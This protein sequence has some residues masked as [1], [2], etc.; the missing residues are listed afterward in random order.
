[1]RSI[2]IFSSRIATISPNPRLVVQRTPLLHANPSLTDTAV[3][4]SPS[5]LGFLIND[6]L[7]SREHIV[8][9]CRGRRRAQRN[10]FP[11]Q[12]WPIV[13][14]VKYGPNVTMAEALTLGWVAKDLNAKP[15]AAVR[16]PQVYDAF[17]ITTSEWLIGYIV[18]EYIDALDCTKR[19]VKLVVLAVQTLI[20]VR[21]PSSAPGPVGGGP[22]VHAF[23]GDRTSP[24]TYETVEELQQHMDDVNE[25]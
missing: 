9:M 19:D 15:E 8:A 22:V 10:P 1:M 6:N 18:M 17:S 24:F 13:A 20:S 5:D 25:H 3:T 21:G 11:Q 12:A 7:P 4:M 2:S 16:I 23:V 14:W